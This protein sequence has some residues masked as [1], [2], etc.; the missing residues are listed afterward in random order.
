VGRGD[1][2]AGRPPAYEAALRNETLHAFQHLCFF[3]TAV[4]FWWSLVQGGYGRLG[5]GVAVLFVFATSVHTSVLGA[6][7][8]FARAL[9]YPLYAGRGAAWGVSPLEDQQLAG[10]YMWVPSALTFLVIGLALLAAW[11]GEAERRVAL[12]DLASSPVAASA[13]AARPSSATDA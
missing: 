13:L 10:L 4:L 7:L 5:Y 12:G 1:A 9:W 11:M 8:T 3:W 6:L 2:A